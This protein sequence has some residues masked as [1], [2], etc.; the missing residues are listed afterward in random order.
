M[1]QVV[2]S[3]GAGAMGDDAALV[4]GELLANAIQH[5]SPPLMIAVTADPERVR[6]A[7]HDGNPRPPVRPLPARRT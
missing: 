7:V 3:L 6:I 1:E 2:G 5:G 4:A